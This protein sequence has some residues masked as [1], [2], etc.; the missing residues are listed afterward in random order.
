VNDNPTGDWLCLP[1]LTPELL[2]QAQKIK[3]LLTGNLNKRLVTNPEFN[4]R[5]KE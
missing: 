5:E 1:P 3:H 4:G 2:V